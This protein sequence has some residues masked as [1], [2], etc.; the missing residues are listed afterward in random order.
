MEANGAILIEFLAS[1]D[2]G[3]IR[4]EETDWLLSIAAGI[5]SGLWLLATAGFAIAFLN[6]SGKNLEKK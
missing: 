2:P 5:F 1:H 4:V 3:P 6:T